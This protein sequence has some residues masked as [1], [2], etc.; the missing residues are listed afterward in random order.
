MLVFISPPGNTA[1]FYEHS[2]IYV[3]IH[4][5]NIPYTPYKNIVLYFMNLVPLNDTNIVFESMPASATSLQCSFSMCSCIDFV[6]F[7][8]RFYFLFP[9]VYRFL[10]ISTLK[11]YS[12]AFVYWN[13]C[14]L[15]GMFRFGFGPL[16]DIFWKWQVRL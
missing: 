5:H 7:C 14:H 13:T 4:I 6:S 2:I 12:I 8:F 15:N 3:Y 9:V 11:M 16:H 10:F 1:E